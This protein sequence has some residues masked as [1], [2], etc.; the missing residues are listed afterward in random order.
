MNFHETLYYINLAF[1][2]FELYFICAYK[3]RKKYF[4]NESN[5][6]IYWRLKKLKP[7]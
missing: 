3:K 6:M 4:V 1:E 2:N 7:I 5:I